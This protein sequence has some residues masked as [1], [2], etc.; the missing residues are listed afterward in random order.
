MKVFNRR[1]SGSTNMKYALSF[2]SMTLAIAAA[3][4]LAGQSAT[5]ADTLTA[6]KAITKK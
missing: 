2:R 4:V 1:Y 5:A 3:A 6:V